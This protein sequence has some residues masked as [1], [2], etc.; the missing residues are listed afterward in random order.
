ML[1]RISRR[2]FGSTLGASL[3]VALVGTRPGF[4][5]SGRVTRP[6]AAGPIRLHW[7]EN[8]HGPSRAAREAMTRAQQV[9]S[10]YPD[11]REVE[12]LQ[13]IAELHGVE[14]EQVILGCGSEE[15]LRMADMA[16]L[17]PDKRLVVAEPTFEAVLDYAHVTRARTIKVPLTS[18]F[19]HD[20]AAMARACDDQTGMVYVCNPNNPTGTIVGH[21]ELATFLAQAPSESTVVVDEAYHHFVESP[22][23]RS[24]F[25]LLEAA[26]NLVVV[27]TF[28][29]IYGMAG[30]R[31]G[32]AV[33]SKERIAA[34]RRHAF[35]SNVNA[36]VLEAALA[37][38]A[39]P[40]LVGRQRRLLNGTRTWLCAELEKDGRRHI[41]SQ[42]NFVMID[43]GA[44]VAP[45]VAAFRERS[46]LV[47][48]RFPSLPTWLRVSMGTR[49]EMELFLAALRDIVK[50]NPAAA[51]KGSGPA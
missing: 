17:G 5:A 22:R 14:V 35:R 12:V 23:Y 43:V 19:R 29:K 13:A 16:F 44:D 31:L 37:S 9:A 28:S 49:R 1:E 7:N 38:L 18:D 2:R 4:P 34:M 32:Y 46:I 42:T 41:P 47:G 48:R 24:G 27:R 51:A 26:P 8:P 11:A 6:A 40:D 20:L 45:V 25:D 36:A 33:G 10:R 3:A 30:M 15:T 50:V 21:E 39:D